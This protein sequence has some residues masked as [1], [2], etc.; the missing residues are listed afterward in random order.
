VNLILIA[1]VL[2]LTEEVIKFVRELE[3]ITVKRLPNTATFECELNKA[4]LPV[5]WYKDGERIRP[6]RHFDTIEEGAVHKLIIKNIESE[7]DGQYLCECKRV[8]SKAQLNVHG[9]SFADIVH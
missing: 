8:R 3:D 9:E 1:L 7:D 5:T 4:R 2:K 6:G